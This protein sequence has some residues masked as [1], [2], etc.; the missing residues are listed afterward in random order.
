MNWQNE[1]Y[2]VAVSSKKAIDYWYLSLIDSLISLVIL[3]DKAIGENWV[4]YIGFVTQRLNI[5]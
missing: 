3:L 4:L 2:S 5:I 1:N